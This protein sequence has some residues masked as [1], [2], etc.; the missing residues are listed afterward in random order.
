MNA[1][2][3]IG[4][5]PRGE[6]FTMKHN[7]LL[8]I[9]IATTQRIVQ[10]L[11][12]F[13]NLYCE[14]CNEP[15]FGGV[16]MEWQ[17]R[18]VDAIVDTEKDLAQHHLISMNIAN[19]RST[20]KDPH[21]AVSTVNFHYCVPPDT[22]AMNDGLNKVIGE[23]ET[24]SVV[25]PTCCTVRRPGISCLLAELCTITLTTPSPRNTQPEHCGTTS[26]LGAAALN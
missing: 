11:K 1:V 2:N 19:G 10:E 20:V 17:H 9:Q 24:V 7:D 26:C 6:A 14:I 13:D 18:I 21:P 22:V 15:Y 5:V 25:Q 4:E 8:D 16:T 3:G 23:N 12:E